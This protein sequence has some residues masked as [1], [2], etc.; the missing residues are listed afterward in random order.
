MKCNVQKQ[1]LHRFICQSNQ[2][3]QQQTVELPARREQR[4]LELQ[5]RLSQ[6]MSL[7]NSSVH[8][9]AVLLLLLF[10]ELGQL[11][12]QAQ[13]QVSPCSS[14]G[15]ED[16]GLL[17]CDLARLSKAMLIQITGTLLRCC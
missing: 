13:L 2:D 8:R 4:S 15:S 6:Q 1:L 5:L 9:L 12:L 16:K 17:L 7:Q 11:H 10:L 3:G 14:Q